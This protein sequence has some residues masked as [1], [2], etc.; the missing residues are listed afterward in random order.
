MC[1][2]V[3]AC[4]W[5][6][7]FLLKCRCRS[8]L[9]LLVRIYTGVLPAVVNTHTH[10]LSPSQQ[11][12]SLSLIVFGI[13]G[14]DSANMNSEHKEKERQLP[15]LIHARISQTWWTH[16]VVWLT[17]DSTSDSDVLWCFTVWTQGRSHRT[18][19]RGKCWSTIRPFVCQRFSSFLLRS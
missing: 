8:Q 6:C 15:S 7:V 16:P 14:G 13:N 1:V 11:E 9:S 19:L 12:H 3:C 2:H 17:N 18:A 10:A 5:V 4:E